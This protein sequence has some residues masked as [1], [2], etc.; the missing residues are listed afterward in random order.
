MR[1]ESSRVTLT[2]TTPAGSSAPA[3]SPQRPAAARR[4]GAGAAGPAAP[5]TRHRRQLPGADRPPRRGRRSARWSQP[6]RP[7]GLVG[8]VRRY[9]DTDRVWVRPRV[10]PIAAVPVG[11]VPQHGR[12]DRPG[13]ARQHHLRRAAGVRGRRRSAPRALAHLGPGRR[14]DGP[15]A[16]RHQPAPAGGAARRPAG[17]ATPTPTD[18]RVARFESA[19][20]AA[21]SVIV[22]AVPRGAFTW[23]S[24]SS[25]GATRRRHGH[26]RP[27]LD[28]LAE[29]SLTSAGPTRCGPRWTQLRVRRVGDTLLYLTGPADDA[30]SARWP[31]CAAPTRRSS[32]AC[33]ARSRAVRRPRRRPAG[34]RGRGRRRLRRRLG[35]G[36]RHGERGCCVA[37]CRWS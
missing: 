25:A 18:R 28:L 14:A 5:G 19:C 12:A 36:R 2:V 17:A 1:G 24:G 8:V 27:L 4:H 33:S 20:E 34:A 21:A 30:T 6:P 9:G 35:R 10:H 3:W 31:G 37:A 11:A 23:S 7:A 32:P 26:R 22:A 16:R 15:R 13:A 29:A